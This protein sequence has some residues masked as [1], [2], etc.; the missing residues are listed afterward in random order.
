MH[1][2]KGEISEQMNNFLVDSG[3]NYVAK[4]DIFEAKYN[5]KDDPKN[6]SNIDLNIDIFKDEEKSENE[7][8]TTKSVEEDENMNATETSFDGFIEAP[9]SC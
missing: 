5:T 6:T 1:R 9:V 7:T 4:S 3:N 8:T 2:K